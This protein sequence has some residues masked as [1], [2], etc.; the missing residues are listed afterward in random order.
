MIDVAIRRALFIEIHREIHNAA[1]SVLSFSDPK[2]HSLSY[3]PSIELTAAEKS[4]LQE[5]QLSSSA[6]SGLQ[7]LITDACNKPMFHLFC[8]FD[9]VADPQAGGFDPWFGVSL[10]SKKDAENDPMLHD[11][12][13]ESYWDYKKSVA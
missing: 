11:E 2:K 10:A 13:F 7:K 6:K 1:S 5:L 9:G 4:A 12:L 8:L 3:P